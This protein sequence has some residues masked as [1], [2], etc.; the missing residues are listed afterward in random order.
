L[1]PVPDV[2]PGASNIRTLLIK[3]GDTFKK[4]C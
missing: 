2:L 1:P 3:L 4:V